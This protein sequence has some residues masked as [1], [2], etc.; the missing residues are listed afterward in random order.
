MRE[1]VNSE[2]IL[3]KIRFGLKKT[4]TNE[5]LADSIN[6]KVIEDYIAEQ[7]VIQIGCVIFGKSENTCEIVYF[8]TWWQEIREKVLPQWWLQINPSLKEK[9]KV[10]VIYPTLDFGKQKHKPKVFWRTFTDKDVKS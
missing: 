3:E 9:K 10:I 6:V 4:I 7:V 2:I 5:F 8:K 1:K